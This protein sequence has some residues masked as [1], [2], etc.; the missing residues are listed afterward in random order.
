MY[1][2]LNL[3]IDG[4]WRAA[5]DKATKPVT[6]PATEDQLGTIASA[7]ESDI[8]AALAAAQRGFEV[9]RKTGTWERAAI[10]A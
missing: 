8:D 5:S 7:T 9:W 10:I 6:D 1:D 3:Y 4:E 2:D